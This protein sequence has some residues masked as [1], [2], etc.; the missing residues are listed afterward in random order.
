MPREDVGSDVALKQTRELVVR[1]WSDGLDVDDVFEGLE[2]SVVGLKEHHVRQLRG[3][4]VTR[5]CCN[6]LSM[7]SMR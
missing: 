2:D 5:G 6:E 3:E 4:R 1:C 7:R